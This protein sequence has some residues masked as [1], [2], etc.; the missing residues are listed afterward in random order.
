MK[1]SAFSAL[2]HRN[3]RLFWTG[4]MISL[5]GT[6]MQNVGQAWLVLT[7]TDS[8]F[9]LGLVSAAQFTPVLLISLF[10]GVVIDRV[11]KRN[12]LLLT[13]SALL[14]LALILAV[15]VSTGTVRYWHVLVLAGLLGLV[16]A[17]DM[18]VRQS[19]VCELVGGRE[20]LMNAIALNSAIF[21]GARIAG[22]GIAGLVMAAW[23]PAAAF[24]LNSASFLAV[25]AGLWLIPPTPPP[26]EAANRQVLEHLR[27]G[28]AYIRRVQ[29]VGGPLLLLGILSIFAMNFNVLVPVFARNVLHQSAKGYGF[30]LSSLGLGALAGSLTLAGRARHG[31]DPYLL[32]G[33]GIG[34]GLFQ[35][36]LS[37]VRSYAAA[38]GVL[39]L[40][41]W[42]MMTFN[43]SVNTTIQLAVPDVLRG[44]V[45]SVYT[46]LL[47]G[48][49]PFGALF[50][51]FL[52]SRWGAAVALQAGG[53]IGLAASLAALAVYRSR[54]RPVEAVTG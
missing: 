23:G 32:L 40:A 25:I 19:Y 4:Q 7:L 15:L 17:F 47:A 54:P 30:L 29:A 11:S 34:L 16:N 9:L 39:A 33:A 5:I 46:F 24:Y 38:A 22:P 49:T 20:D 27:E 14:T 37:A 26:A 52:S 36:V 2:H 48:V 45:M 10:A 21:N 3:F 13:Q 41:G 44:R 35:I 53:G 31:P 50:A 8:P 6:W 43:A 12:L 28:L 42:S 51:G 1:T 18:P